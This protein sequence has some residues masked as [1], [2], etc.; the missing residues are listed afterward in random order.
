MTSQVIV[1]VQTYTKAEVNKDVI[2]VSMAVS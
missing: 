1:E 2:S